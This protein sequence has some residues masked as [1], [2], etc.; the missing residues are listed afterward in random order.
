MHGNLA[1]S[2]AR[3]SQLVKG[4][5][6]SASAFFC[7][8]FSGT[9]VSVSKEGRKGEQES[10]LLAGACGRNLV[11]SGETQRGID[12]KSKTRFETRNDTLVPRKHDTFEGH[13]RYGAGQLTKNACVFPVQAVREKPIAWHLRYIFCR[14]KAVSLA[15]ATS[16]SGS[17]SLILRSEA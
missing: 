9:L 2:L 15:R 1:V 11:V 8:M 12:A 10:R 13:V 7:R 6:R 14:L 17:R 16:G 3:T 4:C 5:L